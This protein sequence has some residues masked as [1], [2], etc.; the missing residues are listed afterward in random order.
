MSDPN[1]DLASKMELALEI[2][3]LRK[4]I[5]E[6][7]RRLDATTQDPPAARDVPL[8]RMVA[9]PSPRLRDLPPAVQKVVPEADDELL[10]DILL[11]GTRRIN[12]ANFEW[13]IGM[14]CLGLVILGP[15]I[16]LLIGTAIARG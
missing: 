2:V 11:A 4:E 1:D 16:L 9:T 10:R 12:Q 5:A 13:R 8:E 7:K 15:P 14:L 6:L 3:E